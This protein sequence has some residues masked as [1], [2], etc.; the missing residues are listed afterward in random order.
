M[1][2]KHIIVFNQISPAWHTISFP[3]N[4]LSSDEMK[5]LEWNYDYQHDKNFITIRIHRLKES[6][7]NNILLKLLSIGFIK[8]KNFDYNNDHISREIVY[9]QFDSIN[10]LQ[11]NITNF[12]VP[13]S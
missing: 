2:F 13:P 1:N 7:V 10:G 4:T 12:L 8:P 11:L 3:K 9:Q 5:L 6:Q